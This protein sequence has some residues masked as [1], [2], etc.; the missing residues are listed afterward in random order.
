MLDSIFM[1]L[2]EVLA[3]VPYCAMVTLAAVGVFAFVWHLRGKKLKI[4][5]L[6]L[7]SF[8]VI[9]ILVLLQTAF[10]SREMGSR[11]REI[12]WKILPNWREDTW[13]CIYAI[14]NIIMFFPFGFLL[15][16]VVRLFRH[17][18]VSVFSAILFSI[19]IEVIQYMTECGY[20]Q[21]EDV[22]MNGL[23]AVI[24]FVLWRLGYQIKVHQ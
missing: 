22:V 17:W 2:R 19:G 5:Q 23:G 16:M 7:I 24:G 4:S 1:D 8:F 6:I 12:D 18:Y 11:P 13:R 10:F 21:L 9:Y 3:Y 20:C 14:E 15:P